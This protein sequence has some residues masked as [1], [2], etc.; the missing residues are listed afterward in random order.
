VETFTEFGDERG[1]ALAYRGRGLFLNRLE[2]R[3]EGM[4]EMERAIVHA[5]ACGDVAV[6]RRVIGTYVAQLNH[7]SPMPA[8]EAIERCQELLATAKTDRVLEAVLK[9]FLGSFCAMAGCADQALALFAESSL[10]LDD[11]NHLVYSMQYRGDVAQGRALA[12]DPTGAEQELLASFNYFKGLGSNDPPIQAISAAY[13]LASFYCDQGRW[14]EAERFAAP[15]RDVPLNKPNGVF[16]A[17]RRLALEAR[18]AA[19]EGR[20]EEAL[21]MATQLVER[22]RVRGV[23]RERPD[24]AAAQWLAVA[25]VQRAAGHAAE[26]DAARETALELYRARGNV[27]AIDRVLAA[28]A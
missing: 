6:R 15:Y 27:A 16:L 17:T 2:R 26:A 12:G 22:G 4:P 13:G 1:L 7:A 18:L 20:I 23:D 10:V 8:N 19:H 24:A 28:T 25:E 3:A 9:R 11:L 14:E 21:N 5:D